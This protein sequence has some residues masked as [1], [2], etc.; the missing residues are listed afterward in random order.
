M[1]DA[2]WYVRPT[3]RN[4]QLS[5]IKYQESTIS[6]APGEFLTDRTATLPTQYDRLLP[7]CF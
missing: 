3:L 7:A 1:N 5:K 4:L 2:L 6:P